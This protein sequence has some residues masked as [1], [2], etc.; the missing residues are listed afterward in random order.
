MTSRIKIWIMQESGFEFGNHYH[1][2]D[3]MIVLDMMKKQSYGFNTFAALRVGEIQQK[4]DLEDWRHIQSKENIADILTKGAAPSKIAAGSPWQCG[5]AWLSGPP[6]SYPV[7]PLN[8][9]KNSDDIEEIAKFYK[10]ESKTNTASI[11]QTFKIKSALYAS[12][13]RSEKVILRSEMDDEGFD[14]LIL[15]CGN[16]EKL[17]RCVAYLLRM[18]GKLRKVQYIMREMGK[19]HRLDQWRKISTEISASEYI[20]AYNFLIYWEQNERLKEAEIKKLVPKTVMVHLSNFGFSV[21]HVVLGGRIRNFPVGFSSNPSIPIIPYGVLAKLVVLFYHTRHH[22]EVDTTVTFVRNDLWVV[23]A[24]KIASGIDARCKF[25]LVKRNKLASQQM[26]TLPSFRT[27]VSPSFS[28]TCMDLFGPYEIRDDCVK[29]GPRIYKKVYGVLFTCASTRAVHLD[30]AVDYSTESILHTLRRL[31]A[32]RGDVRL[33]I[34]DPG[35]QLMS[36]SKELIEWR[37]GWDM[38]QLE[39]FGASKG[40]EWRSIMASSQHQNGVSEILIKLVKGV[41]KSLLHALGDTKLSLNEMNTLM[42]EVSN[43]VNERPIGLQPNN[44]TDCEYLSPNSLLLGRS[45]ARITSGPFQPN[46]VFTDDPKAARTRFLLVQSITAQ[47]W[48]VWMKIYFPSLL[49]RQK[50]HTEKRNLMVNDI[51][52][53]KEQNAFRGEWRLCRVSQV[54]PDND[55]KIRN[56]EVMVKPRQGGSVKY[57]VTKPIYLNR[58]VS[59]LVVIEGADDQDHLPVRDEAEGMCDGEISEQK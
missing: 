36:A 35:S 5:P 48:K 22:R 14:G 57:V 53:L 38:E 11:V 4:T 27:E 33:I 7:T 32:L 58:H 44:R 26:G 13:L 29:K 28:V 54:F 21:P 18:V 40:L 37:K 30:I 39:R 45:S 12:G 3:S 41:K 8:I 2:L 10:K 52:V 16:L 55:G 51:C 9:K 6:S 23:K 17:V 47:F 46:Q 1:F 19:D 43:L 31:L 42:L 59:N 20:D 50:W 15:R 24:R 49:V 34:S 56:V 25:C